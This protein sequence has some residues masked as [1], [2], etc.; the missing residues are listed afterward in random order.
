MENNYSEEIDLSSLFKG[1]KNILSSLFQQFRELVRLSVLN[2]KT[3][4]VFIVL[5]TGISIGI[6]LLK[7]TVYIT[8][9]TV[10][11]IRLNNGQCADLV[12]SL[13]A[14]TPDKDTILAKKLGIDIKMAEQVK[15][16]CYISITKKSNDNDSLFNFSDFK[17]ELKVYNAGILDSL[18]KRILN[19]LESNEYAAKRK[20][21]NKLYL[22]QYEEKIKSEITSVDSLKRIVNKSIIPRSMGNG[23]IL[24]ESIDPVK[25]YEEGMKLYKS[26][27]SINQEKELNNSFEIIVGYAPAAPMSDSLSHII[28][29]FIF[30]FILGVLWLLRKKYNS[31]KS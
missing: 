11:H 7:K 12:N 13:M 28:I 31:S 19:F 20:E 8:D 4:I 18:Q 27:L 24:G 23:I 14:T 5:G 10:S 22:E 15:N 26:K 21:I 25:V 6:F 17:V 30:G 3:L 29:G 2:I 16:I 9:F 1:L